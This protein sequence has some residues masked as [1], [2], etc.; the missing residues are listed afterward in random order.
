[1]AT[2]VKQWNDGGSLSATYEGSGDGEAVF[3]SDSY[4]GI[5]REMAVSFVGGGLTIERKVKQEGIRLRFVTTDNK[6]FCLSDSGRFGVLKGGFEP[7]EPP[8][9][10]TYTRLM[11]LES[12]GE[13][14]INLDYIVKED[15]VIEMT[16]IKPVRTTASEYMFGAYDG[17]GS[18]WSYIMS[19]STYNSFGSS[20][21]VSL[22]STRWKNR[23]RIQRGSVDI[24]GTTGSLSLDNMPQTPLYLFARNYNG[25]AN[26]FCAIKTTGFTITKT[27]GEV[28]MKLRPC[29]RDKDGVIGMI[30]V[31][32]G[33][34][35]ENLGE[36][37]SFAYSGE[38]KVTAGYEI[39][40]YLAFNDDKIIDTGVYGNER[41]SF[42][43]LFE[44]TD[45]SG[46]DYLFGCSSNDRI[47]GYLAQSG[48]WRYGNGYPTFNTN[49][50]ILHYAIVTAGKTT[51]DNT[52]KTFTVGSAFETT[53]TIPVGGHKPASGVATPN[54][55][56]Y[57]YCFRMQIDDE[58]VVD[59]IPCKR[60]SDGVEGFWDCVTQTFFEPI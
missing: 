54:Y 17:K 52:S 50:V 23:I 43:I 12:N 5:D 14:Y 36:G 8:T 3:T 48:Y 58:Y 15:D 47:T 60:L 56:G 44:R 34:F 29:K 37:A 26:G 6:V 4:E 51:I 2:K 42:E 11:F 24:E 9:M 19:N 13:Q 41:T 59:F 45:I 38:A 16:F 30:D 18:L 10:E 1:M 27:S 40:D 20:S 28:V 39:I 21:N 33:K 53:F 57:I 49:D 46:S 31:V 7:E 32:S 35:F 25:S 22:S 55:Q